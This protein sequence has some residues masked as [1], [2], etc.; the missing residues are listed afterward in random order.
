MVGAVESSHW[1]S[2]SPVAARNFLLAASAVAGGG[3]FSV[4]TTGG[5]TADKVRAEFANRRVREAMNAWKKGVRGQ[6]DRT[7]GVLA[8]GL[9]ARQPHIGP[10][11]GIRAIPDGEKGLTLI[12]ENLKRLGGSHDLKVF[13]ES[14]SI[15]SERWGHPARISIYWSR[16]CPPSGGPSAGPTLWVGQKTPVTS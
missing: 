16:G 13:A 12:H 6:P 4:G 11:N 3:L 9:E 1:T 8:D 10:W 15:P 14:R 2:P 7:L 5:A